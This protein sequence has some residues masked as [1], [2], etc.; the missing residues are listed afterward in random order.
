M[1]VSRYFFVVFT[2]QSVTEL[3]DKAFLSAS[4]NGRDS[5]VTKMG[6]L[7]RPELIR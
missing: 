5:C 3:A 1:C 2:A 4:H 6:L 7:F